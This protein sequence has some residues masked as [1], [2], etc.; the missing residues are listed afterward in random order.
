MSC[1]AGPLWPESRVLSWQ[2][3][4]LPSTTSISD[5]GVASAHLDNCVKKAPPLHLD[6]GV[7][8]LSRETP[9]IIPWNPEMKSSHNLA[10]GAERGCGIPLGLCPGL[11]HQPF[12]S[13]P[14]QMWLFLKPGCRKAEMLLVWWIAA[15]F[16]EDSCKRDKKQ[17]SHPYLVF[18]EKP[19][20]IGK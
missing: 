4:H 11:N 9:A 14:R 5:T 19:E 13:F 1:H 16:L 10:S 17:G 8:A 2:E 7:V 6:C 12:P 15:G 20:S 3:K 18:V